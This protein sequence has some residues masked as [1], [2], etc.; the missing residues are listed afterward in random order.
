[1]PGFIEMPSGGCECPADYKNVDGACT[2]IDP[3]ATP[4]TACQV[5]TFL[6]NPNVTKLT[7]N[8]S[9][10]ISFSDGRNPTDIALLM[11][12]KVAV[13]TAFASNTTALL[14]LGQV[15]PGDYE[16]ELQEAGTR[17]TLLPVNVGCSE[18]YVAAGGTDGVCVLAKNNC[19]PQEWPDG[20]SCRQK[21]DM[22]VQA[23]SDTVQMTVE[24]SKK[25]MSAKA[26]AELRLKNGDVLDDANHRIRWRASLGTTSWLTLN[27]NAGW[28][29]SSQPVAEVSVIAN[30]TGL[31]DTAVSGPLVASITFTSKTSDAKR[32]AFVAGPTDV[33]TID[34][35]LTIVAVPY[36]E[37]SDVTVITSSGMVVRPG[38]PISAGDEFTVA[39]KAFDAERIPIFRSDRSDLQLNLQLLGKMSRRSTQLQLTRLTGRNDSNLNSNLYMATVPADWIRDPEPVQLIISS[40]VTS[41][42]ES[43]NITL[44]IVGPSRKDLI[45]GSIAAAVLGVLLVVMLIVACRNRDRMKEVVKSFLKLEIRTAAELLLDVW[46]IYGTPVS[47]YGSSR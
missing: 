45:F 18:G 39:V 2:P 42:S 13:R 16:V 14:G 40:G 17:C 27:N 36:V 20:T 23:S 12:P 25:T 43:Y 26:S 21:A 1:M 32:D 41:Q 22:T 44:R 46:D 35:G 6:P 30:V 15:V 3:T 8:S 7:D 47:F 24:K 4:K 29:Y 28:V 38:D 37:A 31:S 19:T 34:V 9:V 11:R 5:A 10:Y 33:R